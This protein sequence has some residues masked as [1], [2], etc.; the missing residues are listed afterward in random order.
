MWVVFEAQ[1][2]AAPYRR[3]LVNDVAPAEELPDMAADP[4]AGS[5]SPAEQVNTDLYAEVTRAN[6][7]E[8]REV[9]DTVAVESRGVGNVHTR[10]PTLDDLR[11]R[12]HVCVVE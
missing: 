4:N 7:S 9:F 5:D 11:E 10:P 2:D 12:P 6:F 8:V 3:L 1:S